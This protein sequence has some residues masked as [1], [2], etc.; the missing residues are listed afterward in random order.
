MF[1]NYTCLV[2]EATR[3]AHP[4][5][6]SQAVALLIFVFT[7]RL[8]SVR[9][10]G[11]HMV[12]VSDFKTLTQLALRNSWEWCPFFACKGQFAKLR[13]A[14]ISFAMSVSPSPWNSSAPTGRIFIKFDIWVFFEKS[15][16]IRVSFK[17]DKKRYFT[18]R[19]VYIYANIS[20]NSS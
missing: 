2:R 12:T 18:W 4:S 19:P 16:K 10:S 14:I 8:M 13:Q 6:C 9:S 15:V 5:V 1:W 7:W 17:S 3:E 20:L 11:W